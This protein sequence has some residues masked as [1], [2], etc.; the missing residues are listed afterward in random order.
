MDTSSCP[1]NKEG[2]AR[3]LVR[4]SAAWQIKF[5]TQLA[6]LLLPARFFPAQGTRQHQEWLE[7]QQAAI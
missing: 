4:R 7:D 2:T 6:W 3:I 5:C 1:Q